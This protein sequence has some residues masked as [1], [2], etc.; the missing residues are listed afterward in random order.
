MSHGRCKKHAGSALLL[1]TFKSYLEDGREYLASVY[2]HIKSFGQS[3][4]SNIPCQKVKL[5]CF[6][7]KEETLRET[8][9]YI[10]KELYY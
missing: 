3:C 2:L 7:V 4:I 9:S 8:S 1:A 10:K 5:S 6:F